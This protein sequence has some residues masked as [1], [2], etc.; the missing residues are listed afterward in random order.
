[1]CDFCKGKKHLKSNKFSADRMLIVND[2]IYFYKNY[3]NVIH[4][5][6]HKFVINYCPLCGRELKATP[7]NHDNCCRRRNQL[8]S[9]WHE[10]EKLDIQKC[11]NYNRVRPWLIEPDKE[12][13]CKQDYCCGE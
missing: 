11:E 2:N 6:L 1:M 5:S 13:V 4:Q 7:E 12:R 9:V 8:C 3:S 10:L